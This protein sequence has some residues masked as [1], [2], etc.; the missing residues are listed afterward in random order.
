M[1]EFNWILGLGKDY[2]LA[3]SHIY[4]KKLNSLLFVTILIQINTCC[5][6]IFYGIAIMLLLQCLY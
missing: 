6:I 5:L 3:E 4:T 2:H 1:L